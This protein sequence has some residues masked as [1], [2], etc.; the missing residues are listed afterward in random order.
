MAVSDLSLTATQLRECVAL[1]ATPRTAKQSPKII[2][3]KRQAKL[4]IILG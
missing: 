3:N 1:V 2:F 4:K